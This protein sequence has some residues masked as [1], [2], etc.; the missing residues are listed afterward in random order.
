MTEAEFEEI[1]AEKTIE[2]KE[3]FKNGRKG[4]GGKRPKQ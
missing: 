2:L 1:V 3:R 4:G